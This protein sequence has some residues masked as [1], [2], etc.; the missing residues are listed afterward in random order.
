MNTHQPRTPDTHTRRTTVNAHHCAAALNLHTRTNAM[1]SLRARMNLHRRSSLHPAPRP[2]LSP[3][4]VTNMAPT[5]ELSS[6]VHVGKHV[7]CPALPALPWTH[8]HGFTLP[9]P[10]V[11]RPV[12]RPTAPDASREH[13]RG[14]RARA[15]HLSKALALPTLA[16]AQ[17]VHGARVRHGPA[18]TPAEH[19]HQLPFSPQLGTPSA[20]TPSLVTTKTVP[21]TRRRPL[22][23]A[24]PA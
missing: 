19:P 24:A 7:H 4:F 23:L 10:L 21:C 17:R 1:L 18:L 13:A 11:P 5:P 9:R 14:R 8:A 22:H 6:R 15:R 20:D 12:A 2:H 16:Q 3:P